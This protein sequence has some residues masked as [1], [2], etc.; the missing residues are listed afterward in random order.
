MNLFEQV[1]TGQTPGL[2][3][4]LPFD[5]YIPDGEPKVFGERVYLYGSFDTSG[6]CYCSHV[7]HAVSAPVDD[8]TSWTDH[9]V[10]FSSDAVPWS[11]AALYAPDVLL[12]QGIYYLF[13]CMADGSEGVAQSE[14]PAGPFLNPR[15]ITLGGEPISGIDPSVLADGG[16]IYYTWGQFSL[17]VGELNDDLCSLKPESVHR[18]VLSNADDREG[19]HEGSS[20]RKLGG[21]YC[22]IYASEYTDAFPHHGGRPT[23]LDYAVS[24]SPYGPYE[25][26]G[27]VIDNDGCDPATWNNHGSIVKI[28][29]QWYT[30]YHASSSNGSFLRRAR[31][32]KLTVDECCGRIEQA[33]PT[34]NGFCDRLTA[35][36]LSSPLHACRFFGGAYAAKSARGAFA[37]VGLTRGAGF[38]F[39]PCRFEN[40]AY[41]LT[42]TY[43]AA[44]D[45]RFSLYL[46]E[47]FAAEGVLKSG[48]GSASVLFLAS[49]GQAAVRLQIEDGRNEAHCAIE[50][51]SFERTDDA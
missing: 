14:S 27:T 15:R 13:F 35:E 41:R 33:A 46:D 40:G 4:F 44:E 3:P 9:G 1:P 32:E 50:R 19:F 38:A 5:L 26:R 42:L 30:F 25:R 37:A 2:N 51:L 23:K 17:N 36:M 29:G 10:S 22:M 24:A 39:S 49:S 20:L 12:H 8:L 47:D 45:V 48:A 43:D 16:Q 11:D 6:D 28:G 18:D 21:R 34:T 7:Y 31:V